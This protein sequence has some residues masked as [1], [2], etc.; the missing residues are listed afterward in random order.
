MNQIHELS[1]KS[2]FYIA[3]F[4]LAYAL[5]AQW[6]IASGSILMYLALPGVFIGYY[7][8]NKPLACFWV[9][10]FAAMLAG[11]FVSYI[12]ALYNLRWGINLLALLLGITL[13]LK[14][15]L[16]R[17]DVR[18]R[19]DSI[20]IL[21]TI[22]FIFVVSISI[23]NHIPA[24][25]LVIS[26]KN[27]FQFYPLLLVFLA[28]PLSKKIPSQ[29]QKAI[30]VIALVQPPL[31]V[32]QYF[33]IVPKIKHLLKTETFSMVD[34]VNGTFGTH[35]Q[36]GGNGVYALF[37]C[38]ILCALL[39]AYNRKEIGVRKFLLLFIYL[40]FPLFINQ[41][42]VAFVFLLSGSMIVIWIDRGAGFAKRVFLLSVAGIG[43]AIMLWFAFNMASKFGL[44]SHD[45]IE[46]TISYN[47]G[48]QGYGRYRLNRLTCLSFWWEKNYHDPVGLFI[49][50]GLDATNE[51]E[52]GFGSFGSVARRYPLYGT[53]L[54]TASRML[55]ETGLIGFGLFL[56]IFVRSFF[57]CWKLARS[58]KSSDTEQFMMIITSVG[59]ALVIISFFHNSLYRNSQ[60]AN[61]FATI[62]LGMTVAF[63]LG[64]D[65][66][67]QQEHRKA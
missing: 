32:Y 3:V 8:F 58:K 33:V 53:G 66:Y 63:K 5:I 35:L 31:A 17:P 55:W 64:Y 22:F 18:L 62:L 16:H 40:L 4:A 52:G 59:L 26:L 25:Q 20:F 45:F 51:S 7:L 38:T 10:L 36:G 6:T 67:V 30:L 24:K 39:L 34:A 47:F 29:L 11:P 15:F 13:L 56:A 44:S 19:K 54:T 48:K 37:T 60:P 42:M 28:Y 1:F 50:H 9:I 14:I 49:G 61:L 23:V 46:S 27:N 21:Y 43:A 12:P 2:I 41:A 57:A 65:S